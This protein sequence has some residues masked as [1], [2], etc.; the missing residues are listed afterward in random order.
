MSL[1]QRIFERAL[2]KQASRETRFPHLD[3]PLKVM[4]LYESDV[5]ERN[6]AIKT[7]RQNLLRRQMDVTM[8]GFAEKKEGYDKLQYEIVVYNEDRRITLNEDPSCHER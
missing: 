5:L 1:K 7:I 6:D 3:R 8:W 2:R 4:L